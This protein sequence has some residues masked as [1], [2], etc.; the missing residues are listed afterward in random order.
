M[1]INEVTAAKT[2]L[3]TKQANRIGCTTTLF[4]TVIDTGIAGD[5]A[6]LANEL[7]DLNLRRTDLNRWLAAY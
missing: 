5:I 3:E 7:S 2:L 1:K 6:I 4:N